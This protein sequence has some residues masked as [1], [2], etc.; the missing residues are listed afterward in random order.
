MAGLNMIFTKLLQDRPDTDE[1]PH[2]AAVPRFACLGGATVVE[3]QKSDHNPI[4]YTSALG[5]T[6][7]TFNILMQCVHGNNGFDRV[8]TLEQYQGRL[9]EAIIPIM[10][11]LV[12][13]HKVDIFLLQEVPSP[14]VGNAFYNKLRQV[15]PIHTIDENSKFTEIQYRF[16]DPQNKV[17]T[18]S[19]S[20]GVF[21][22]Y[23]TVM[24]VQDVTNDVFSQISVANQR[25]FQAFQFTYGFMRSF[26]VGNFHGNFK[27]Q[28]GM[29]SDI[30]R[31][32]EQGYL[33]GGDFNLRRDP[34]FGVPEA[35]APTEP[36]MFPQQTYDAIY[37]GIKQGLLARFLKCF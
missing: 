1:M 29:E 8:E 30:T 25:R 24:T 20:G 31:L 21:T 5:Y 32:L 27:D 15:L 6:F 4:I 16:P 35:A 2:S 36:G 12:Q 9:L 13:Q 33:V 28:V 34:G 19:M 10:Q 11:E 14:G 17:E 26:H 22:I 7:C 37:D 18:I 23:P 3:A